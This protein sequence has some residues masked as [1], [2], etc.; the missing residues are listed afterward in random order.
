MIDKV[1]ASVCGGTLLPLVTAS[2]LSADA[3]WLLE[4]VMI[5]VLQR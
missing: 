5:S 1:S 2:W 4:S 3:I